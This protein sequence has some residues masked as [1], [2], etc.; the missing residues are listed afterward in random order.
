MRQACFRSTPMKPMQ[1]HWWKALSLLEGALWIGA[2]GILF[3]LIFLV[4]EAVITQ[5]RLARTF[6]Q[7]RDLESRSVPSA[8]T[9]RPAAPKRA[10]ADFARPGIS[11]LEIPRIGLTAMVLD[12]ASSQTMRVGLGHITG[13]S[14]PGE[15]GNVAIAGHRDTFF[16]PLRRIQEGDEILLETPA[17][18]LTYRVS[19]T[20]IVDPSDV[21]VL[22]SHGKDELTLVTCYPFSY[23]GPAPKRFIVHA[24]LVR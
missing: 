13:T 23:L 6:E 3:Y 15:N 14:S 4:A 16:R 20:E 19:S 1:Q 5:T 18:A 17:K 12:G 11:R 24:L 2:C 21:A 7:S 8:P 9:F 22:R 10:N